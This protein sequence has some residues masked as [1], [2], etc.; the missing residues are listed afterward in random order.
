M[1]ANL[2]RENTIGEGEL[3]DIGILGDFRKAMRRLF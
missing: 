1:R 2:A 3:K